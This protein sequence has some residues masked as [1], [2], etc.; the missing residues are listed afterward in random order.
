VAT[1]VARYLRSG[2]PRRALAIASLLGA[3]TADNVGPPKT[4]A[5]VA[6]TPLTAPLPLGTTLQLTATPRGNQGNALSGHT[7]VWSS[8]D[9]AVATVNA[10]GVASGVS[11][12]PVTITAK[13]D[14]VAGSAAVTVTVGPAH[15]LTFTSLPTT[16]VAGTPITPA[17]VVTAVVHRQLQ[18][19]VHRGA[20]VDVH[21]QRH[22]QLPLACGKSCAS[23]RARRE[24]GLQ[25]FATSI[26]P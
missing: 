1:R 23:S 13:V 3:C 24:W 22:E 15:E 19:A 9:S 7:V 25:D 18:L 20:R 8:S 5:S 17:I 6:V 14:G 12:G 21:R 16:L 2:Y 10:N 4:V 11:L 26:E